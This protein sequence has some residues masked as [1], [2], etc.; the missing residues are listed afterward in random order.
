MAKAKI[1][2]KAKAAAKKAQAAAKKALTLVRTKFRNAEKEID[3]HIKNNPEKAV[4][5][6]AGIGA[7]IGAVTTYALTRKKQ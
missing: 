7:A 4:L 6:A 1:S 3:R 5:L 2:A